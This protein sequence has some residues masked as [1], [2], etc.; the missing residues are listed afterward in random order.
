MSR[1]VALQDT[2]GRTWYALYLRSWRWR[3][4]RTLALWLSGG[5]CRCCARAC[6]VHHR[7]YSHCGRGVG[8]REL[9]D[10]TPL[11]SACHGTFHGRE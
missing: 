4:L 6:E 3:V 8:V 9:L 1:T 5:Q 11:C 10:L 7:A 2:P